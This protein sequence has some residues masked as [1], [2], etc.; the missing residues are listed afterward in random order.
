MSI[1]SRHELEVTQEKLRWLEGKYTALQ[2]Q[3]ATGARSHQLTL[4]SLKRTINQMK[5]EIARFKS[6]TSSPA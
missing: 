4:Q 5:E 1:Q 6:R 3:P 2:Q